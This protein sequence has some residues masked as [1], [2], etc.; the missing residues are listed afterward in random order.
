M[1]DGEEATDWMFGR[2]GGEITVRSDWKAWTRCQPDSP[3]SAGP[4]AP[5]VFQE[6][7]AWGVWRGGV[8]G[9]SGKSKERRGEERGAFAP[10]DSGESQQAQTGS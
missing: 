6:G 3:P 9:Q 10:C 7:D 2:R 1:K 5:V 8:G 4:A